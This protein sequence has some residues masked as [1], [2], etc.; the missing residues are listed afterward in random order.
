MSVYR[1]WRVISYSKRICLSCGP[2][3]SGKAG[4]PSE[5]RSCSTAYGRRRGPNWR[6]EREANSSTDGKKNTED[7]HY[8]KD[9][10]PFT[11]WNTSENGNVKLR[12]V[13]FPTHRQLKFSYSVLKITRLFLGSQE[14]IPAQ[15]WG[16]DLNDLKCPFQPK[17]FCGSQGQAPKCGQSGQEATGFHA[18]TKKPNTPRWLAELQ[19]YAITW[20]Y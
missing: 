17:S 11:H 16:R 2:P 13:S 20:L 19:H 10:M 15:G 4:L 6:V 12:K 18:A 5:R 9:I 8:Y 1:E 3:L 7:L 14:S